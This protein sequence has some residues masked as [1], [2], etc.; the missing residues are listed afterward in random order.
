MPLNHDLPACPNER[1]EQLQTE[2]VRVSV[3]LSQQELDA[4]FGPK[5]TLSERLALVHVRARESR[6][7]VR[8]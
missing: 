4:W 6:R 8:P 5:P 1:A 3:P 2:A 7:Q